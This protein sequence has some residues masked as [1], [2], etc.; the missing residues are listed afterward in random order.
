MIFFER[1]REVF[2]YIVGSLVILA[3]LVVAV[4]W[5]LSRT[6][7]ADTAPKINS[8]TSSASISG[9]PTSLEGLVYKQIRVPAIPTEEFAAPNFVK[10][11][12]AHKAVVALADINSIRLEFSA[13]LVAETS[14]IIVFFRNTLVASGGT[15]SG[16]GKTLELPINTG[17]FSTKNFSTGIYEVFYDACFVGDQCYKGQYA[18]VGVVP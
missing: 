17:T 16:D 13:K 6:P 10:A 11:S 4:S 7:K 18:F 8:E 14:R 12:P 5:Y 1:R 3:T 2:R 9:S 15:L